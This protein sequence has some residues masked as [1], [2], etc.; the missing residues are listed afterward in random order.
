[1]IIR[2]HNPILRQD[3]AGPERVLNPR[4]AGVWP[5]EETFKEGISLQRRAALLDDGPGVDVHH[6]GRGLADQRRKAQLD[7]RGR[8]W[9]SLRSG[10]ER[11]NGQ[12]DQKYSH[13]PRYAQP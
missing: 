7:L 8:A 4:A 10:R 1:M 5:S 2:H 13:A 3:H 9:H 6:G 12:Q 11:Q